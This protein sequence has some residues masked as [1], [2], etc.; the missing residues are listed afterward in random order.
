MTSKIFLKR[1]RP[2]VSDMMQTSQE[3]IGA[4][5]KNSAGRTEKTG[6]PMDDTQYNALIG[7]IKSIIRLLIYILAVLFGDL[8]Y[9]IGKFEHPSGFW[10]FIYPAIFVFIAFSEIHVARKKR[11]KFHHDNSKNSVHS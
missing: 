1:W 5:E 9:A 6:N 7:Y 11:R 2:A 8:C 4:I 10:L 3:Y